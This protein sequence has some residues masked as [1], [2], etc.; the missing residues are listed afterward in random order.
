MVCCIIIIHRGG[1]SRTNHLRRLPFCIVSNRSKLRVDGLLLNCRLSVR[2]FAPAG[3]VS[4]MTPCSEQPSSRPYRGWVTQRTVSVSAVNGDQVSA[5]KSTAKAHGI[6]GSSQQ[7]GVWS[8]GNDVIPYSRVVKS[9]GHLRH[10]KLWRR[11]VV[12]SIPDRGTIV[13]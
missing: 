13:G 6:M 10:D 3:G 5:R 11:E 12:G 7:D 2:V 1:Q 8:A 4:L 9:M